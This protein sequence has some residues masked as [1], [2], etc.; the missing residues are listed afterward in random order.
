MSDEWTVRLATRDDLDDVVRILNEAG[1]RLADRGLDQW[2]HD[3]MPHDRMARMIARSETYVVHSSDT[4][5][6]EATVTLS[7]DP[8]PFWSEAEREQQAVYL[9]KLARSDGAT[10]GVGT[11]VMNCWVPRWAKE[12][13]YEVIRLDAWFTNHELHE[14]YASRG[15]TYVRHEDVPG[16]KSGALFEKKVGL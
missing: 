8:G 7:P 1:A 13:G 9:G 3:W 5:A 10:P 11:W 4:G 15:W 6:L 2:G 16:N 14:Y 12:N